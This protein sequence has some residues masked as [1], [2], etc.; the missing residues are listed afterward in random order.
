MEDQSSWYTPL[1]LTCMAQA[2]FASMLQFLRWQCY[3]HAPCSTLQHNTS[4][5]EDMIW[6]SKSLQAAAGCK[7]LCADAEALYDDVQVSADDVQAIL[8]WQDSWQSSKVFAAGLYL[9]ICLRALVL[10]T[11]ARQLFACIHEHTM[12]NV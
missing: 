3:S 7:A 6:H 8:L 9:L 12:H 11:K 4:L 1:S 10:G 2:C 5:R